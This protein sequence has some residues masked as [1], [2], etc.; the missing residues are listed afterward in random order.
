MLTMIITA[1]ALSLDSQHALSTRTQ[2]REDLQFNQGG[3]RNPAETSSQGRGAVRIDISAEARARLSAA[4][5]TSSSTTAA[6][7]T[8]T[9]EIDDP[10]G[11]AEPRMLVLARMIEALTGVRVRIVSTADLTG[12]DTPPSTEPP[13]Q[14]RDNSPRAGWSLA[15]DRITVHTESETMQFS[16]QGVVQTADGRTIAFQTALHMQRSSTTVEQF[17]LR[18]GDAARPMKDPLV[19]HFDGALPELTDTRY[20]FDLDADGQTEAIPFVGQG[21]GV[22]VLDR[23]GNGQID[24][25]RELFGALSG[26]GFADLARLDTDRNGWI[27]EA[28]P[29]FAQLQVWQK[30]AV[31]ADQYRSLQ[32]SGIGALSLARTSSPYSLHGAS[33]A[34]L[35][36]IRSSGVYL[37]ENGSVGVM[38]QIDLAV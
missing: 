33:D 18:A 11:A 25:G 20:N 37:N 15:Y 32:A 10:S 26:D 17:S 19:L 24:D 27:D 1:S 38:Q 29:A 3:N 2:V 36:Q 21:S 13:S 9:T 6:T 22:L 12:E 34:L 31:G 5:F 8:G 4:E 23:N 14:P 35:G 7:T 28:D 16:A 30:D